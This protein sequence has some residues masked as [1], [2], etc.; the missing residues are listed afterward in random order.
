MAEAKEKKK[1]KHDHT[2]GQEISHFEA[3]IKR[4]FKHST[5][6]LIGK[7]HLLERLDNV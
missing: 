7:E 4:F 2:S 6:S 5:S 3:F 1:F